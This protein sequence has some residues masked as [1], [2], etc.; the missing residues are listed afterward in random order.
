MSWTKEQVAKMMV[1]AYNEGYQW[2][3]NKY[4]RENEIH[5]GSLQYLSE[6]AHKAQEGYG[7]LDKAGLRKQAQLMKILPE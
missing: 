7:A 3:E 2:C 1:Y 6:K 4:P 5:E